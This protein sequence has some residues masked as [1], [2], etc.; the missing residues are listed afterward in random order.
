MVNVVKL[1]ARMWLQKDNQIISNIGAK[2]LSKVTLAMEKSV[3]NVII[4]SDFLTKACY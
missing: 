3:N 1:L 4:V 2:L